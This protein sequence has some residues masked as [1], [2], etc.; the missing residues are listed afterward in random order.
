MEETEITLVA[1]YDKNETSSID[2]KYLE[3]LVKKYK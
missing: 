1:I 2:R 3:S